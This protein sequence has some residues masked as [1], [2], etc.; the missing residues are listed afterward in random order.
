[1]L[2]LKSEIVK[3][4]NYRQV[5]LSP[6]ILPFEPDYD[7]LEK[8]LRL[9]RKK[10]SIVR[11]AETVQNDDIITMNVVYK[12]SGIEKKNLAV[13]IG[14]NLFD[15]EA[16][17]FLIGK[18]TGRYEVH[19]KRGDVQIEL[20]GIQRSVFPELTD[21]QVAKWN[22]N[23]GKTVQE[24][25]EYYLDLQ[26]Q[27]DTEETVR[28]VSLHILGLIRSQCEFEMDNEEVN[29]VKEEAFGIMESVLRLQGCSSD[30]EGFLKMTGQTK[31]QFRCYSDIQAEYS[32]Q[33]ALLGMSYMKEHNITVPDTS[34]EESL[35]QY[36]LE[37]GITEETA[38]DI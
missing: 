29:A 4:Y 13:K 9:L 22:L 8:D 18:E 14:K 25:K 30:D 26:K 10:H 19:T 36:I 3:R 35:A 5:D 27:E 38:R 20:N 37:T 28:D 31:E 11:T 34:Y 2:Q 24:V 16:E 7:R 33:D 12:D 6:F 15:K 21:E 32:L 17:E 1:M 23:E